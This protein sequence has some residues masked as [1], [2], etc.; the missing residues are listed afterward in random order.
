MHVPGHDEQCDCHHCQSTQK[1]ALLPNGQ[2][3]NLT[4]REA[5]GTGAGD[6]PPG[7]ECFD[8]AWTVPLYV[9][10]VWPV[11]EV[12]GPAL[13][14]AAPASLAARR[15]AL[16]NKPLVPKGRITPRSKRR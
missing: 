9:P 3:V 6:V 5:R 15:A 12:Q 2:Y 14:T 7:L 8:P 13:P 4:H 10:G 11:Q 1:F 16:R